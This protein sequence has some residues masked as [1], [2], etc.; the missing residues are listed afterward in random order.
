MLKD[1]YSIPLYDDD[2]NQG[3]LRKESNARPNRLF[4]ADRS[5]VL[6]KVGTL[7]KTKLSE[8]IS[9]IVDIIRS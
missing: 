9:K 7:K 4:A 5:I 3:S 1:R 2:F 8:I 6:Y